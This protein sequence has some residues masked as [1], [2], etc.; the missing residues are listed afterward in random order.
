MQLEGVY[1]NILYPDGKVPVDYTAIPRELF[2]SRQVA[3]VGYAEQDL[4]QKGMDYQKSA[5]PFIK[6]RMGL[7]I[8]DRWLGKISY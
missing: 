2:S 4:K 3:I 1:N 8:E 5:Y 6:T 7:V